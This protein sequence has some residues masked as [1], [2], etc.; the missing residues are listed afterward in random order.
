MSFKT[1]ISGDQGQT[2]TS[3][4]LQL[5]GRHTSTVETE[6]VEVFSSVSKRR[7]LRGKK[8]EFPFHLPREAQLALLDL[9]E[10]RERLE[11]EKRRIRVIAGMR[12]IKMGFSLNKSAGLV[13]MSVSGLSTWIAKMRQDGEIVFTTRRKA[14]NARRSS[15]LCKI[16][17]FIKG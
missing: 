8:V 17:F 15:E 3:N 4:P 13:D 5:G 1:N 6:A 10:F 7:R 11:Q 9:P 2:S 16:S 14:V 12:L